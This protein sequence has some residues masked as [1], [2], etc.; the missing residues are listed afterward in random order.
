VL[1]LVH[2][3]EDWEL[4][5]RRKRALERDFASGMVETTGSEAETLREEVWKRKDAI[6]NDFVVNIGYLPL[7]VHW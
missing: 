3:K 5:K 1:Q 6:W 7:T 4:M 2:L